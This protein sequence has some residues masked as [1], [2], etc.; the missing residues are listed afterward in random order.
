[1]GFANVATSVNVGTTLH[2]VGL[3][4]LGNTTVTGNLVAGLLIAN[5]TGIYANASNGFTGTFVA[6]GVANTV[7]VVNGI[8]ISVT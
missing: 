6:N 2:V 5:T 1:M 3:S 8:I 4:S 7:T